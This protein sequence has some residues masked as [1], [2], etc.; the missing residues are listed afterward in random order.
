MEKRN[1]GGNIACRTRSHTGRQ[2]VVEK[3]SPTTDRSDN[4]RNEPER[5]LWKQLKKRQGEGDERKKKR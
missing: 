5:T 2:N 3:Q 4:Q 1:E